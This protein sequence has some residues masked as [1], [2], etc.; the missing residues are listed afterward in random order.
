MRRSLRFSAVLLVLVCLVATADPSFAKKK[1]KKEKPTRTVTG[2]VWDQME[3]PIAG[4]VIQLKNVRTLQVKS[5]ITQEKGSYYFHGLDPNVDYQLT[6]QYEGVRS[7]TRTL[8][9]FDDRK[10]VIFNFKLKLEK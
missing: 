10:E 1:R 3:N 7:R 5:F 2:L 4:A 8:S 6:A 9:T